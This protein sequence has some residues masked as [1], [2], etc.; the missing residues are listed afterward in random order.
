V[1]PYAMVAIAGAL[2][3]Y[4]YGWRRG[5]KAGAWSTWVRTGRGE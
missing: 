5:L 3:G 4:V 2:V 1:N